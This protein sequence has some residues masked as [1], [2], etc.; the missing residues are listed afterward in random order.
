MQSLAYWQVMLAE[1][2][3]EMMGEAG[4]LEVKVAGKQDATAVGNGVPNVEEHDRSESWAW[5]QFVNVLSALHAGGS[6][7]QQLA[8][9]GTRVELAGQLVMVV[10]SGGGVMVEAGLEVVVEGTLMA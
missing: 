5:N 7:H 8:W 10:R 3:H 9:P 6:F 4:A 2:M 1:E